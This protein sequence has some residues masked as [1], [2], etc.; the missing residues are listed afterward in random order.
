M[1]Q[2]EIIKSKGDNLLRLLSWKST[3][4][5]MYMKINMVFRR[6][7]NRLVIDQNSI[8]VGLLP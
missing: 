4:H 2:G 1:G 3:K 5:M 8:K 6:K 7:K